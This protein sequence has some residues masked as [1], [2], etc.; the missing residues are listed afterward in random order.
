MDIVACVGDCL[1][2]KVAKCVD[3]ECRHLSS[4][5]RCVHWSGF[6]RRSHKLGN[7]RIWSYGRVGWRRRRSSPWSS[8]RWPSRRRCFV[9]S[10]SAGDSAIDFVCR[11]RD[12]A[13]KSTFDEEDPERVVKSGNMLAIS[14][15]SE[16]GCNLFRD[17]CETLTKK[18][19]VM[20]AQNQLVYRVEECSGTRWKLCRKIIYLESCPRCGFNFNF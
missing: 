19:S 11:L 2:L 10:L 15:W 20:C 4:E 5:W 3:D 13:D 18:E 12:V 9:T 17:E 14:K 1:G 7:F 8:D 16:S 6:G